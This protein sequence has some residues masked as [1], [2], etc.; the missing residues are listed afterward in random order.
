M[1]EF[2]MKL[3]RNRSFYFTETPQIIWFCYT[4]LQDKLEKLADECDYLH[5]VEGFNESLY[6]DHDPAIPGW[7]I[8]DDMIDLD[9]FDNVSKQIE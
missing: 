6:L 8:L 3:I 7:I 5:L 4:I 2:I 1:A 9:I